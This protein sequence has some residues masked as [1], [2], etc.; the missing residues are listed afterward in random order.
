MNKTLLRGIHESAF[1]TCPQG[2]QNDVARLPRHPAPTN[3]T[4]V[5]GSLS[6]APPV[7]F[8]SPQ[9]LDKQA[10]L[11]RPL[12][13]K[14]VL[15]CPLRHP[16]PERICRRVQSEQSS[17]FKAPPLQI[18]SQTSVALPNPALCDRAKRTALGSTQ[19]KSLQPALCLRM[20]VA[21]GARLLS[22]LRTSCA[23]LLARFP[24][25]L[26]SIGKNGPRP[27]GPST[28]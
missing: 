26:A 7:N 12:R 9:A 27:N 24:R 22:R 1:R 17:G 15:R 4:K 10:V 5:R 28:T 2:V 19:Q 23:Q 25:T 11:R 14:A 16:G 8:F 13:T 21:E 6:K 3:T 18:F 20:R